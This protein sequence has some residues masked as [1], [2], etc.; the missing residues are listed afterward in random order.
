MARTKIRSDQATDVDFLEEIEALSDGTSSV[1][2]PSNISSIAANPTNQITVTSG[3]FIDD[4]VA[5]GDKLVIAG[6]NPN[7]GT[8]TVSSIIDNDN[9]VQGTTYR[10]LFQASNACGEIDSEGTEVSVYY[11]A[12][13]EPSINVRMG[14]RISR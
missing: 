13:G 3:N 1:S 5:P 2:G 8:F 9:L 10:Y 14:V 6:G 12:E 11:P 7:D 4:N